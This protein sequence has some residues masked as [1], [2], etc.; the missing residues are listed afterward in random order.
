MHS[1]LVPFSE[2]LLAF[3]TLV[4]I[5]SSKICDIYH[6]LLCRKYSL[7]LRQFNLFLCNK[8]ILYMLQYPVINNL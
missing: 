4:N 7:Y 3:L 5:L 6:V 8:Y 1:F 2:P